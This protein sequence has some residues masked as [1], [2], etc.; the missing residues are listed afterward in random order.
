[1]IR[2]LDVIWIRDETIRPPG[3]K[4]V[5]CV[6]PSLGL[7]FRINTAPK[8]QHAVALARTP[9]HEFLKWDSYLE[10]GEPLELDEYVVD[11]S[12]RDRG[13]IGTIDRALVREIVAAIQKARTISPADKERLKAALGVDTDRT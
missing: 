13:V 12:L 3:P 5:V 11:E 7:F 9:H 6:E 1:M 10:C 4:M 8:W 2:A